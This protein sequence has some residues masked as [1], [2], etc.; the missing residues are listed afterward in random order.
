MIIQMDDD[1]NGYPTDDFDTKNMAEETPERIA[2]ALA[3]AGAMYDRLEEGWDQRS[4]AMDARGLDFA[5]T[6]DGITIEV[7]DDGDFDAWVA[8]VRAEREAA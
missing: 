4:A 6:D 3:K 2:D 7:I 1:E 5:D 8:K